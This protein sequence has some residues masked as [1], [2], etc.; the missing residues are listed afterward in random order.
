MAVVTTIRTGPPAALRIEDL[1]LAAANLGAVPLLAALVRGSPDGR[2]PLRG[3]VELVAVLGA[4]AAVATRNPGQ[5]R[6]DPDGLRGWLFAGP[7]LGG[8]GLV[9]ADV[10][11]HLGLDAS[12][13]L[14][15][16]TFTAVVAAFAFG[17][18]LP[19]LPEGRRRLLVTPFVLVAAGWF[20]GFVAS[21]FEGL[22]LA[23]LGRALFAGDPTMPGTPALAAIVVFAVLAG[24][25]TFYAMLVVAPRE[26]AA[27]EP[28]PGV[29][30]LRYA[31]FV[32]TAALGAGAVVLL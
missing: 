29:W 23:E 6:L 21:L 11:K 16:L 2:D 15:L 8:I 3:V 26:L 27:P 22:D 25:A 20:T 9:G 10:S 17:D 13:L 19:V 5:E 14:A 18:R 1:A 24:S 4:I 31:V 30:L 7:L 28:Q 12:W 32:V